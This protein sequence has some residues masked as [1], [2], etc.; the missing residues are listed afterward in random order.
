[1][2]TRPDG[3]IFLF[4][5]S[6]SIALTALA[7]LDETQSVVVV[8]ALF[9]SLVPYK[10]HPFFRL[11]AASIGLASSF[12]GPELL[13]LG[14]LLWPLLD[15]RLAR[16]AVAAPVLLI[17]SQTSWQL[18]GMLPDAGWVHSASVAF[19]PLTA[20]AVAVP[21]FGQAPLAALSALA[22]AVGSL[23][24]GALLVL[25]DWIAVDALTSPA[26]RVVLV[27]TPWM[28]AACYPLS[29]VRNPPTFSM[30][31]PTAAVAAGLVCVL[32]PSNRPIRSVVFDESHGSWES[33][34]TPL[35]P[36]A[37]GRAALYSYSGLF[38][39][40]GRLVESTRRQTS[41]MPLPNPDETLFILKMPTDPLSSEFRAALGGWVQA[42]GR[43]LVVGDHTDLFDTTQN[44]NAF[45]LSA[46]GIEL[47]SD[48]VFSAS[49]KPI[50]HGYWSA[51]VL[52][53]RLDAAL[54]P[55]PYQTGA[56]F[57]RLPLGSRVL[58]TYGLSF[59]EPAD[60]AGTNRFGFFRAELGHAYTNHPSIVARAVGW[61]AVA[62]VADSTPWSNFSLF[63]SPYKAMFSSLLV[64][65]EQPLALRGARASLLALI[66]FT[67]L[68]LAVRRRGTELATVLALG[69]SL[70]FGL[71]ISLPSMRAPSPGRDYGL[72]VLVGT[73]GRLEFLPQ[74]LRPGEANYSR[75]VAAM[76]KFRFAPLA[77]APGQMPG[78]YGFDTPVLMLAPNTEQ[79]PSPDR[80]RKLLGAGA[81][82]AI[83]FSEQAVQADRVVS[84]LGELGLGV[85]E[86]AALAYG[87]QKAGELSASLEP[88]P[89]QLR[90]FSVQSLGGSEWAVTRRTFLGRELQYRQTPGRLFLGF[91]AERLTDAEVGT[92]WEDSMPSLLGRVRESQLAD[93][94]GADFEGPHVPPLPS[95]GGHGTLPLSRYGVFLDGKAVQRGRVDQQ[96]GEQPLP[97]PLPFVREL[98]REALAHVAQ[99]CKNSEG[100]AE[101]QMPFVS[102]HLIEWSVRSSVLHGTVWQIE[103]IHRRRFPLPGGVYSVIYETER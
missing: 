81:R 101:C 30:A 46:L 24:L 64:T 1:V 91:S 80:L 25:G 47:A 76:E 83:L 77:L 42:G 60:Y 65:L 90:V 16:M 74:L 27:L 9:Y 32:I 10:T 12:L 61:G 26:A 70:G 45:L 28:G 22:I 2:R 92:I 58:A 17:L 82:I 38:Q 54:D 73:E 96:S 68:H 103:L 66:C 20:L 8:A 56:S 93:L 37:F 43:L 55:F 34:A 98:E 57:E 94:L 97:F 79:L 35:G 50:T 100:S 11:L 4:L 59:S 48:A 39:Y 33:T 14:I 7:L 41:E 84:W 85:S 102:S 6:G 3:R 67:V 89:F 53:G 44:L 51:G 86:S 19:I 99:Y 62:V 23:L 21:W 71:S 72:L 40:A 63:R 29:A 69:T 78:R 13:L 75:I 15:A 36:E 49:G 5:A 18:V 95:M 31:L 52:N 88:F 87:H